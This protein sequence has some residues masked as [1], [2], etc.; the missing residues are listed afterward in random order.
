LAGFVA[1]FWALRLGIQHFYYEAAAKRDS[2]GGHLFFTAC[3][4][5]LTAVFTVTAAGGWR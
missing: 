3:F 2:P 4:I 1:A 5:Y